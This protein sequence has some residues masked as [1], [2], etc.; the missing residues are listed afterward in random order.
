M[1]ATG[2]NVKDPMCPFP[3]GQWKKRIQQNTKDFSY[4]YARQKEC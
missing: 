1:F 2:D 3:E 4:Y